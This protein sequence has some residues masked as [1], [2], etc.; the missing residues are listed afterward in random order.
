VEDAVERL[1]QGNVPGVKTVLASVALALAVYQL[2]LIAVGYGKVRL[3]FLAPRPASGA[4]RASGDAIVV[5]ILVVAF[6]CAAVY[7]V[8]DDM[9]LH[10]VAG[11]A[12]VGVLAAKIA[13]VR[14]GLGLGRFLP[15]F[16]LTVFAL[17]CLTWATSAPEV[18]E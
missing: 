17:L 5:L 4:H 7:G 12:L 9:V 8:E 16:G 15:V 13:V 18:L 6:V 14:R 1:A 11:A 2:V 3:P 10:G